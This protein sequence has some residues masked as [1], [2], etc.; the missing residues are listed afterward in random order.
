VFFGNENGRGNYKILR[1]DRG[2]RRRHVARKNREVQRAGF[3]QAASG[4]GEAESARQGRFRKCVLDQGNVR[5][6][7][8]PPPE[9]TSDPPQ[10]R[11]RTVV[12]LPGLHS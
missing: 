2:G 1:E 4:R 11:R 3:L 9:G 8:A 10:P 12:S 5:M 7:S 6:T